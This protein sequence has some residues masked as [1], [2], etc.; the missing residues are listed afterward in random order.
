MLDLTNYIQILHNLSCLSC[1]CLSFHP[2][3]CPPATR[4]PFH[5]D[6][7]AQRVCGIH[8]LASECYMSIEAKDIFKEHHL[9]HCM[10]RCFYDTLN[11]LQQVCM[12]LLAA[13]SSHSIQDSNVK[14][15]NRLIMH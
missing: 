13:Y 12:I 8:C 11:I 10:Q 6:K 9:Q 15:Y 5:A 14:N 1:I 3:L 7:G 4:D 2:T